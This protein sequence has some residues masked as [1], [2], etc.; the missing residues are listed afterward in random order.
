MLWLVDQADNS[1]IEDFGDFT[2]I[3]GLPQEADVLVQPTV[4]V[5]MP[6]KLPQAWSAASPVRS[7]RRKDGILILRV[8]QAGDILHGRDRA[9][10]L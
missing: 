7:P 10:A 4:C 2:R 6:S 5:Q 8:N 3:Q 9:A 1:L